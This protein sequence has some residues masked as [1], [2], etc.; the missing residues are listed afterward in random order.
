MAGKRVFGRVRKLPSGR[1][2]A[3]YPGPDGVDR[4]APR[5]F[6]TKRE[7][8]DWLAEKQ[9][10]LRRGDWSDP[11]AGKA[12]F[13]D[14]ARAWIA[15]RGLSHRTVELYE[16]LLRLHLAPTFGTVA[17]ADVTPAGVRAWRAARLAEGV[18][19]STVAKAYALMRAVFATAVED[20]LIRRN[21]CQIKGG[22]KESTPER[23]IATVGEVFAVAD[24]VQEWY[25]ALVLLA[26]FLGLRWGELVA[27]RRRDVDLDGGAVRVR[28]AVAELRNGQRIHKQP[29][30]DAGVRTVGL[31]EVIA[32]DLRRHL[33]RFAEPGPDGRVFVGAKG[34]TPRR[35]H[36]N[37]LWHAACARAGVSGL[38]FHDLR[39]TGNT[40]A[41][42]TGASTKELMARMGHSTARAALIYQ[43]AT[44]ERE[45]LIAQS[46]SD[47]VTRARTSGGRPLP[48]PDGHGTG[49]P[50]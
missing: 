23:P 43:H 31:P 4:P 15:E 35:N 10:E 33:E 2:Q 24:A 5:T 34:T 19:P 3:R 45:R 29:K 47:L 13:G 49:T 50:G 39:H 12:A 30:S 41:A 27:L 1:Y 28:Q 14:F 46:V 20:R 16:S 7:A 48:A 40:L 38:R 26:A 9:T 8:D 42:S 11:D 18:G 36:F 22:S 21:P 37:R 6:G 44:A 25:R 17:V 32:A